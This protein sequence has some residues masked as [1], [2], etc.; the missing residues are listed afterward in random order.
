MDEKDMERLEYLWGNI[1]TLKWLVSTMVM[2]HPERDRL[3]DLGRDMLADIAEDKSLVAYRRGMQ[4]VLKAITE[5]VED[6]KLLD[7]DP[8]GGPFGRA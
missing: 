5:T 4:D 6:G 2:L 8:N 1:V 3:I 7:W